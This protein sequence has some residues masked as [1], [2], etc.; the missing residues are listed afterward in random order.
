MLAR[1][2]STVEAIRADASSG[3]TDIVLRAADL[4]L[5]LLGDTG[6]SGE[7]NE[8]ARACA[9]AQPTMAG[10]LAL[11]AVVREASDPAAS[12]ARFQHQVRRAP[13]AIARHAADV[14]LLAAGRP[15]D[16]RPA[17][18]LVTCSSSRAVEAVF[19]AVGR[20]ATLTVCCAESRPKQE[21]VDLA[22]RLAAGGLRVALFSDAGISAA[23][24]GS[25]GVLVGAD[26]VGPDFFINK[27]GTAAICA[28]ASSQG[29]PVYVVASREKFLSAADAARLSLVEGAPGL[30]LQSAPVGVAVR[31]PYFERIPLG[32]VSLIVSDSGVRN[33]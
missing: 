2:R 12:I 3:S 10:L 31:N 28:L 9:E 21:G 15:S 8:L 32:L 13:A 33:I 19:E 1:Y 6:D 18:R 23:V 29:V 17:L 14:L 20:D 26:A 30:I 5:E 11:E 24:P 22:G 27:V 4:L 16:R 25:D 7:L